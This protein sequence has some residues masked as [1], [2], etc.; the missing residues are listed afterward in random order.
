MPV[1]D[2]SVVECDL[3]FAVFL[4]LELLFRHYLLE[5]GEIFPR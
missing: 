4:E 2:P 1:D 5:L 3:A